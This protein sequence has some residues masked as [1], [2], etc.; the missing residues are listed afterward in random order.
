M[1]PPEGSSTAVTSRASLSEPSAKNDSGAFSTVKSAVP[2]RS[3]VQIDLVADRKEVALPIPGVHR[4]GPDEG[5]HVAAE[6][7]RNRDGVHTDG[8]QVR[9]RHLSTA[10][11]AGHLVAQ[12]DQRVRVDLRDTFAPVRQTDAVPESAA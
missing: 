9:C 3:G 11:S 4:K 5:F 7:C 6:A 12:S 10:L 1:Q 8:P 2:S